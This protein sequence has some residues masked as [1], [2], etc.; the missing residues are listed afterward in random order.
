MENKKEEYISYC[1][2]FVDVL[3]YV[4]INKMKR[5]ACQL[6]ACVERS[7]GEGRGQ[8]EVGLDSYGIISRGIQGQSMQL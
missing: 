8:R 2:S 4:S 5:G 1:P 6:L 3:E 7:E